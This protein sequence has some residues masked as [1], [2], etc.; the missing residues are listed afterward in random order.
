MDFLASGESCSFRR[1]EDGIQGIEDYSA[2][3]ELLDLFDPKVWS[4]AEGVCEVG[5]G[6]T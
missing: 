4:D 2:A 3:V 5:C 6:V 1:N